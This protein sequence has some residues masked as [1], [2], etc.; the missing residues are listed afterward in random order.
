MLSDPDLIRTFADALAFLQAHIDL[1]RIPLFAGTK[2]H[3]KLDRMHILLDALGRPHDRFASVHVAGTKG[4]GSTTAM[5]A[6][7]LAAANPGLRVGAY[8]SP[9]LVDVRERITIGGNLISPDDFARDTRTVAVAARQAFGTEPVHFFELLT[10]IAFQHFALERVDLAVIEVGLGGRL[11]STNVI[12]PR[13]CIITRISYDHMQVLGHTLAEIAGEKAG[14]MKP[15]V[16]TISTLQDP[17]AE[18]VL[19]RRAREVGAPIAVLGEEIPFSIE[20]PEDHPETPPVSRGASATSQLPTC[21]PDGREQRARRMSHPPTGRLRLERWNA[22]PAGVGIA[23]VGS[24]SGRDQ[25]HFQGGRSST[26]ATQEVLLDQWVLGR[27]Q[28]MN[29]A[30]ALATLH[31]LA[32]ECP[33]LQLPSE[34]SPAT[35]EAVRRVRVLGRLE[36]LH[37]DHQVQVVTD[38]AHN[39]ASIEA[40]LETLPIA[41]P[42]DRLFLIFGCAVEKDIEGML[43]AMAH[44]P[45][46]IEHLI[47]SRTTDNPKAAQAAD[48][49]AHMPA[50]HPAVARV[51]AAPDLPSALAEAGLGMAG[52]GGAGLGAVAS[53]SASTAKPASPI[54]A[55]GAAR[56]G[57]PAANL[58]VI[59]GSFYLAGEAIRLFR[60]RSDAAVSGRA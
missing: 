55:P 17:E 45:L 7:G 37:A 21:A 15:G 41:F 57:Q 29:A 34:V 46:P 30:A 6:A 26:L 22:S 40:L 28:V 19:R 20:M 5:L 52:A 31:L 58:V 54:P 33:E 38:G 4:K 16:P 56:S 35:A 25:T 32:R 51:S 9:H 50:E 27:H 23:A 13:A 47:F 3:F 10:A 44:S 42:H 14:I 60:G 49:L 39:R 2:K 1:E 36:S 24:G 53:G 48:L 43:Q 59:T 18:M 11:D 8:T 12:T